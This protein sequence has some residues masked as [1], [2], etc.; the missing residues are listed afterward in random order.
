MIRQV[1]LSPAD[2]ACV[3]EIALEIMA[4]R[5]ARPL[6][7]VIEEI[8]LLSA[9][10]PRNIR[11]E[12]SALYPRELVGAIHLIGA[13]F[14]DVSLIPTPRPVYET[15]QQDASFNDVVHLLFAFL[16]G[17]PFTFE[18]IQSG[19]LISDVSPDPET[20]DAPRSSGYTNTFDYHTDDAFTD[21]AGDFLCLRCIRNSERIPTLVSCL[22]D[23]GLEGP[24]S[25]PLFRPEFNVAPNIAHDVDRS[26]ICL[27]PVLFGRQEAPYLRINL[28]ISATA[29]ANE[30][31]KMAYERL[32][33]A[34]R[35]NGRA[36]CLEAG[37]CLYIDN[38]R[39]AHARPSYSPTTDGYPR[40][41]RRVYATSSFRNSRAFRQS[42][43]ARVIG[44]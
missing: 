26:S 41:Y 20:A 16:L 18:T 38:F 27:R 21:L 36:V 22:S 43:T 12:F 19:R 1:A 34:V 24:W 37:D 39:A 8:S 35:D 2:K 3:S 28:N 29:S 42:P 23:F 11:Y 33:R 30:E 44:A 13:P 17:Q 4:G 32:E 31:A 40:W 15:H 14:E 5:P 10:L 6:A 9:E 7:S 25:L